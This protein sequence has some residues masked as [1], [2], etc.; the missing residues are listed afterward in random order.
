MR[1]STVG[2]P[3][4]PKVIPLKVVRVAHLRAPER[5]YPKYPKPVVIRSNSKKASLKTSIVSRRKELHK[6]P[7]RNTASDAREAAGV[8]VYI[9]FGFASMTIVG[10][11]PIFFGIWVG[12]GAFALIREEYK[13]PAKCCRQT[14]VEETYVPPKCCDICT[15]ETCFWHAKW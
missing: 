1:R 7:R 4:I 15:D 11:A 9:V 13:A 10:E 5:V 2:R 8:I 14:S 6:I 3:C 12:Y